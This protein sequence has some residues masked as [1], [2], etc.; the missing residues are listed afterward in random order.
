M[1]AYVY[2]AR[3]TDLIWDRGKQLSAHAQFTARG[4]LVAS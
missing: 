1:R 3:T 4:R 2:N